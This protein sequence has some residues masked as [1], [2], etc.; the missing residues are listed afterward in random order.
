MSLLGTIVNAAAILVGGGAGLLIRKGLPQRLSDAVM[1]GLGLVVVYIGIDGALEGQ[2]ALI[3][4][5]SVV[6]G[7]I[8]GTLLDLDGRLDRFAH[9]LEKRMTRNAAPGSTFGEGFTTA[10]LLFCTGA[11]AVV[12]SLNSGLT[13]DHSLLFT[14]S[15]LDGISALVF[16]STLGAG[17]LLSAAA[18]LLYQGAI[19][20]LAS[21]LAPVLSETV[22]AEMTCA[23]SIL[24]IGIGLNLLRV[25]KLPIMN[26]TPAVFLPIVLCMIL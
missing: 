25:T 15:L 14:K 2:N 18:V 3:A 23:G 24:I 19:T 10:T 13:G 16:A 9:G 12:G 20:L 22:I 5:L 11:M 6:L 26:Y 21:L 8:I 7:C 1:A 4:T 17:V